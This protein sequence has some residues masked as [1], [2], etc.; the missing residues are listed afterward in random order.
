VVG[1]APTGSSPGQDALTAANVRR[2][3][4]KVVRSL[5]SFGLPAA[6]VRVS[7]TTSASSK[8]GEVLVYVR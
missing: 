7:Q 5:T 1:V 2:N 4:D 3:A 6:R 8:V